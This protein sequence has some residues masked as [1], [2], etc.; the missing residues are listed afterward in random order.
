MKKDLKFNHDADGALK[1]LGLTIDQCTE[2]F[3]DVQKKLIASEARKISQIS[4]CIHKNFTYEH[5][6]LL[7]T[8][9]YFNEITKN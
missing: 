8:K 1:A 7:A 4:E 6:L 5:I 3:I 2:E 9:E